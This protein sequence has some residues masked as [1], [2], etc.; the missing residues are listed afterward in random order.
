MASAE[1]YDTSGA[2]S[3]GSAASSSTMRAEFS[4]I[5]SGFAKLPDLSGNAN[6]A[7]VINS[8]GT[9]MTVT[10]GA[11]ALAAAFTLSGA[12]ATTLTVT[13]ETN[14]TLPTTGTLAT[15]AGTE[16]LTNKTITAPVLSGTATGTYTLGGTPTINSPTLV[17]PA[18]GTPASGVL[19][20]CTGTAAGLTAGNVTTNANLTGHVTSTGNAAV[21]GSFTLAQLNSA[22]SDADLGITLSTEQATTSGASIDFTGIPSWVKRI[23]IHFVDVSTNGASKPLIQIGDSGGIETTLY[24]STGA[25]LTTS[26]QTVVDST[27][28]FVI[29]SSSS[30]N[31]ISGTVT[32]TLE[33]ASD[34]TWTCTHNLRYG[35][36]MLTGAGTKALSGTLDR[37][38]ITTVNGT[39]EVDAGAINISY[40]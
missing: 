4:L 3:T 37:V 14:V 20:N 1:Y 22:I 35:S 15:R 32:L 36:T 34:N 38:R 29:E 12:F 8:G 26:A 10:V 39:D 18:L 16:T 21:L 30:A 6:K 7:V 31:A 33:D 17:T 19:T 11:L 23:T 13:A 2:P 25:L 24:S 40:E 5:E 28:G 27:A 9:G